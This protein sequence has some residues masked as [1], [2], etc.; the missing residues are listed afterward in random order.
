MAKRKDKAATEWE[1]LVIS[2]DVEEGDTLRVEIDQHVED[3]VYVG[4]EYPN[5]LTLV[6]Q[7]GTKRY[8]KTST[9]EGWGGPGYILGKSQNTM[10][11]PT[12]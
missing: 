10:K 9:L 11:L 4:S 7:Y 8:F 12:K 1:L 5:I 6:D 3:M 2:Q